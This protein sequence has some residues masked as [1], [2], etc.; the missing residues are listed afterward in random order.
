MQY[1]LYMFPTEWISEYTMKASLNYTLT[2]E[3]NLHVWMHSALKI[4]GSIH[5]LTLNSRRISSW[6]RRA[7]IRYLGCESLLLRLP[8][9][10]LRPMLILERKACTG[11]LCSNFQ[12]NN[13]NSLVK[14]FVKM[15]S[16]MLTLTFNKNTFN[17]KQLHDHI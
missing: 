12:I 17:Y 11:S 13:L 16:E 7:F 5:A 14:K 1:A 6:I 15:L 8:H 9:I 3:F 4:D 10:Y 2:N